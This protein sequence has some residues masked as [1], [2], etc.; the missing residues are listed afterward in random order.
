MPIVDASPEDL[1]VSLLR[2]RDRYLNLERS[3]RWYSALVCSVL[4]RSG[5]LPEWMDWYLEPPLGAEIT[6]TTAVNEVIETLFGTT[7]STV[8]RTLEGGAVEELGM[9]ERV[10]VDPLR[11]PG[12]ATETDSLC[13]VVNKRRF[14]VPISDPGWLWNDENAEPTVEGI[15]GNSPEMKHSNDYGSQQGLMCYLP[16]DE[17]FEAGAENAE[18]ALTTP[19]KQCPHWAMRNLPPRSHADQNVPPA[20]KST[21]SCGLSMKQCAS[22][23]AGTAGPGSPRVLIPD[24]LD[25]SRRL[26]V[27][28][29][30]DL[31]LDEANPHGAPLPS[32]ADMALVLDYFNKGHGRALDA[33]RLNKLILPRHSTVL[34]EP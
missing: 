23:E 27:P 25:S 13:V 22:K 26:L 21:A 28:G 11:Q 24:N 29:F 7:T 32:A 33:N 1:R 31:I 12:H 34:F 8:L 4:V 19:R 5:R 15:G 2:L 16:A 10:V 30:L 3:R 9:P 14:N 20:A 17:L 18:V 6:M